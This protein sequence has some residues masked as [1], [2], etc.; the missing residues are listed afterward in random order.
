[1]RYAKILLL[2]LSMLAGLAGCSTSGGLS[3]AERESALIAAVY[4]AVD[5]LVGTQQLSPVIAPG[6]GVR[7]LVATVVDLNNLDQSSPFGRLL[8]EQMSSRLAQMGVAVSE[9]KLGGKLYV[10]RSQGELMLSREVKEISA[11]QNAD[12]VLV[13][14]YVEGGSSVYVTL[15]LVRASDSAISSAFNFSVPKTGNIGFMLLKPSK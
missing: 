5:A 3:R 15:K 2:A 1:M 9:L 11:S 6:G 13:G 14:T 10:S 8:A 12:L 4:D 7:V